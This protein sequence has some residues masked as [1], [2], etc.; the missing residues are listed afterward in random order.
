MNEEIKTNETQ[1]NEEQEVKVAETQNNEVQEVA[2]E[3]VN[4]G[5]AQKDEDE[6][7]MGIKEVVSNAEAMAIEKEKVIEEEREVLP[8]F[9]IDKTSKHRVEVD[10]LSSKDDGKIMSV[11][12]IGLGIDFE[13]DFDYLRH[14]REWFDFTIPSYEEMANYR[15]RCATYRKEMGQMI[16]D[17][18]QLR[19][20]IL[21]WHLKDWS[22]VNK[23][24]NKIDI[25]TDKD[26]SLA[27]S[28]VQKVYSLHPTIIDVVLTIFEKDIL[29]T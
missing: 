22:L 14:S 3:I 12:R 4:D 26:G 16:I 24:G 25:L 17:K 8:S 1:N 21:I 11:S 19:N 20:F 27:E 18:L 28:S 13:N 6:K 23:E 29:L 10:I 15:T 7:R 5:V 2:N 9:F